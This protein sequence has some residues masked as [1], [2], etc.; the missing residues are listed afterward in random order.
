M[1][2]QVNK[3]ICSKLYFTSP[4]TVVCE[5]KSFRGR[6]QVKS[7]EMETYFIRFKELFIENNMQVLLGF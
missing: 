4:E 6:G 5:Q 1:A 3:A 2:P 7:V